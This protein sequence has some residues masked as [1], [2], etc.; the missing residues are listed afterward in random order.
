MGY[1]EFRLYMAAENVEQALVTVQRL[2]EP[3]V[4]DFPAGIEA[5]VKEVKSES[6]RS[7]LM[8]V[9]TGEVNT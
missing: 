3:E 4:P 8:Y 5:C 6:C 9:R 2:E 7:V 1:R